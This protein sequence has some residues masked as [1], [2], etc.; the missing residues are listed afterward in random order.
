LASRPP[1]S[2]LLY[3]ITARRQFAGSA[4]KQEAQLLSKIRE[5]AM[6][7]VDF[8]QLREKD[9]STRNL[10]ELAT[11]AVAAL[12]PGSA[13]KLLINSRIDVA[14]ACGAHGVHLPGDSL[15]ASEARSIFA[16]AG[17]P[18]PVIAVST[19]SAA[20]VALA[21]SHGADF[22]VFGPVFEKAGIA[23]ER[24]LEQLTEIV[25]RAAMP[26]PAMPVLALGGISMAN[27]ARCITTGVAGIAAIRL[28]QN[29]DVTNTVKQLRA[30]RTS[31]TAIEA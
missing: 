19:H 8:I 14:L 1:H 24:G 26:G 21:E 12:P 17:I 7:G 11:K 2:L 4:S 15:Y 6:A 29:S 9:L 22:A 10:E 28:I 3:Y 27:A 13:T 16:S 18:R 23:N 5:C 31:G 25:N 20:E 30:L